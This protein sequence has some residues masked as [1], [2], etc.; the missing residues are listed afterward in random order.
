MKK[1]IDEMDS[2]ELRAERAECKRTLD[3]ANQKRM[4]AP[5]QKQD[6]SE[7]GEKDVGV[8][9]KELMERITSIDERL[10]DIKR[11]GG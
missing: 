1:K 11:G 2:Q 6:L 10:E 8:S 7:E 4:V 5:H 9:A 3:E